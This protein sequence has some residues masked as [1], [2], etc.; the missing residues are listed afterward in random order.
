VSPFDENR[1]MMSVT[2]ATMINTPKAITLKFT[3]PSINNIPVKIVIN[4]YHI[5]EIIFQLILTQSSMSFSSVV[6]AT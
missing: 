6:S 2:V 1:F 3:M 5:V 4:I